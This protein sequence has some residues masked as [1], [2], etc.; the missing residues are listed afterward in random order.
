MSIRISPIDLVVIFGLVI[1]VAAKVNF[2]VIPSVLWLRL[3]FG[4]WFIAALPK[5]FFH[6]LGRYIHLLALWT[7]IEYCLFQ[8]APH[9]VGGWPNYINSEGAIQNYEFS[10]FLAGPYSW[11]GNRTITGV[12]SLT[13]YVFETTRFR[14]SLFL[15]S[16]ILSF[17]TTGILLLALY[18]GF[19]HWKRV[20]FFSPILIYGISNIDLG[21][22][23]SI[24]YISK[25][26]LEYKVVQWEMAQKILHNHFFLGNG[27]ISS[28]NVEVSNY[29]LYFGDFMMLDLLSI[30]GILGTVLFTLIVFYRATSKN[31]IPLLILFI[32]SF[33][34]HVLFCL[35]GQII[36]GYLINDRK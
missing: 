16:T 17:S 2:G 32:G 29:G 18:L 21:Y 5:S 33:H 1:V 13:L 34:Y 30:T 6:R 9:F 25:I 10:G 7:I 24:D 28:H 19:K 22:R 4:L 26:V 14:R 27:N 3:F 20:L 31:F 8:L 12:I 15:L 36:F 23:L 11:G 35:P